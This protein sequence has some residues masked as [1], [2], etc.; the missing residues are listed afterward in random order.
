MENRKD[1]GKAFRDRLNHLEKTPS[2]ALWSKIQGNLDSK[3]RKR[4]LFWLFPVLLI[5]SLFIGGTIVLMNKS[6]DPSS[7]KNSINP[8]YKNTIGV[9]SKN[10]EANSEQTVASENKNSTLPDSKKENSDHNSNQTTI[11][12]INTVYSKTSNADKSKGQNKKSLNSSKDNSANLVL[13]NYH[14][15]EKNKKIKNKYAKKIGLKKQKNNAR[16]ITK[17]SNGESQNDMTADK[18]VV[19]KESLNFDRI[20]EEILIAKKDSIAV[21]PIKKQLKEPTEKD[22][23]TIEKEDD[24]RISISP[25]LGLTYY[26]SFGDQNPISDQYEAISQKGS[27]G[28][29]FGIYALGMISKKLG[30]R[31]GYGKLNIE[32]STTIKKNNTSFLDY[33]NVELEIKQTQNDFYNLFVNDSVVTFNQKIGYSEIPVEVYYVWKEEK[34]GIASSIGVSFLFLSDNELSLKS[35]SVSEF[36]IGKAKNLNSNSFTTNLDV[37][38]SY[39]ISKKINLELSPTFKYQFDGY[40][41]TD[42]FKPYI[43]TLQTG[44]SYKF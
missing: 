29:T 43:L 7:Q 30:F 44:I 6:T 28:S 15:N 31:I 26:G 9:E 5:S 32:N 3:K 4:G 2:D 10:A 39:E 8:D 33:R 16:S 42:D 37:I 18:S 1:I 19:P 35:N 40:S 24:F 38:F 17:N 22:S 27:I 20:K 36:T 41:R 23:I 13:N 12:T 14:T 34:F 11:S 25:Y 21:A